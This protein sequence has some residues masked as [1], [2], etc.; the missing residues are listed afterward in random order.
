M[1][2][3]VFSMFSY[4]IQKSDINS[5]LEKVNSEI[6]SSYSKQVLAMSTTLLERE[7]QNRAYQLAVWNQTG[8][9]GPL[10][11]PF[12]AAGAV[13]WQSAAW[14]ISDL[15]QLGSADQQREIVRLIARAQRSS[16]LLSQ[17]NLF[18]LDNKQQLLIW[19][20]KGRGDSAGFVGIIEA[21]FI[22][23]VLKDLKGQA[24]EAHLVGAQEDTIVS[25]NAND[26]SDLSK[27]SANSA[28][29]LGGALTLKLI[30]TNEARVT[31]TFTA[32][33]L[34]ALGLIILLGLAGYYIGVFVERRV[35]ELFKGDS[36]EQWMGNLKTLSESKRDFLKP[37][38]TDFLFHWSKW[39]D[40][41]Q[42]QLSE[43]QF[44]EKH[45]WKESQR[46][47]WAQL[48]GQIYAPLA[49][50]KAQIDLL[51]V[52]GLWKTGDHK[53]VEMALDRLEGLLNKEWTE[54]CE[55]TSFTTESQE[56]IKA[57][58][59][60]LGG[61]NQS[62]QEEETLIRERTA[63]SQTTEDE[64]PKIDFRPAGTEITLKPISEEFKKTV[65]RSAWKPQL[66]KSI[67]R[68]MSEDQGG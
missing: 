29:L 12:L 61:H 46:R 62:W 56:S 2:L 13:E 40:Q 47:L 68:D 6:L 32:L 25:I 28:S 57:L 24:F 33:Q 45:T 38:L 4:W 15:G 48:K 8:R 18:A 26:E 67:V 63:S 49:S 5:Q 16:G 58:T 21:K 55:P 34:L 1:L 59:A 44:E 41:V 66:P 36:Q 11:S 54:V 64:L 22:E 27:I 51:K 14:V 50:A 65:L 53:N 7:I 23:S 35:I 17:S 60:A 31:K 43:E 9:G 3:I 39:Q 52:K 30:S 19:A 42:R 20:P 10:P 37:V